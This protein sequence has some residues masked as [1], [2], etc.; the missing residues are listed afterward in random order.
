[1]TWSPAAA[2]LYG[3]GQT[4]VV[5]MRELPAGAGGSSPAQTP[6]PAPAVPQA[7]LLMRPAATPATG[8]VISWVSHDDGNPRARHFPGLIQDPGWNAMPGYIRR[9]GGYDFLISNPPFPQTP[10]SS[11]PAPAPGPEDAAMLA[12]FEANFPAMND[13]A[14][15][16]VARLVSTPAPAPAANDRRFWRLRVDWSVDSDHDGT[17]DWLE[18]R[19]AFQP[20][21]APLADAF[22]GDVNANG[23]A[24]GEETD[25]DGD[26]SPNDTDVCQADAMIDWS[27]E[28]AARFASFPVTPPAGKTWTWPAQ[29]N[30]LGDALFED[31]IWTGGV[32]HALQS[33]G[34]ITDPKGLFLDDNGS[35]YAWGALDGA[36][37][38]DT[39]F[40][41]ILDRNG[42]NPRPVM[43]DG[44]PPKYARIF[45]SEYLLFS[46]DMRA[47]RVS[48][49]PSTFAVIGGV[50][51][52]V[53]PEEPDLYMPWSDEALI[54]YRFRW[55]IAA[56]GSIS[57]GDAVG[58][59]TFALAPGVP[60]GGALQEWGH[61]S[62]AAGPYIGSEI[63]G[64]SYTR[65]VSLPMGNPAVLSPDRPA[66]FRSRLDGSWKTPST[67][68]EEQ[69]MDV[70]TGI[71]ALFLKRG[72]IWQNGQLLGMKELLGEVPAG[73]N[74]GDDL[75][76]LD[77]SRHGWFLGRRTGQGGADTC[78]VG[79][80]LQIEGVMPEHVDPVT[81]TT[82]PEAIGDP[83]AG[84]DWVSAFSSPTAKGHQNKLWIMAP[85]GEA[86]TTVMLRSGAS[87]RTSL[88]LSSDKAVPEP[89]VIDA[90]DH[91]FTIHGSGTA[92]AEDA[93][94][95]S[96]GS[97]KATSTPIGVKV[98]KRR[99]I[100]VAVHPV[101]YQDANGTVLAPAYQPTEAKLEAILNRV[102]GKQANAYFNCTVL[103]QQDIHFDLNA[104]SKL[105]VSFDTALGEELEA[106]CTGRLSPNSGANIDI[107][108][109]A[110]VQ[111]VKGPLTFAGFKIGLRKDP[112]AILSA[113]SIVENSSPAWGEKVVAHEIGHMLI[114]PGHPDD[115]TSIASLEGSE[116]YHW[117]R[118]MQSGFNLRD[119]ER[120]IQLV[121]TEWDEIDK[122]LKAQEVA[123]NL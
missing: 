36:E 34:R 83:A 98:M 82:A 74:A 63:F 7:R 113:D 44:T 54:P 76:F 39:S 99:T 50:V 100:Q 42:G 4:D 12:A 9:L 8:I 61:H 59:N 11:T 2:P 105:D 1:M 69:I 27:P 72:I 96:L 55:E 107:W 68:K 79:S 25:S 37:S 65:C 77:A 91:K 40:L 49:S 43:E 86:L 6:T 56:D 66:L 3:L 22:N 10:P 106:A 18:F 85:L 93:L 75:T 29:V 38:P 41:A 122:W 52:P 28:P 121:K 71:S 23:L 70:A 33:G 110:G 111:L 108:I 94:F 97:L 114:H 87:S 21:G 51:V 32:S 90:E 78:F 80:P 45:Q 103:P 46:P 19:D 67:L 89:L 5:L 92:S 16:A 116:R 104:D 53:S 17:P 48:D 15:E 109:V 13:D 31:F 14:E 84:V 73:W 123:G 62:P 24:D 26:G 57:L 115:R 95:V 102:Y 119:K 117:Q 81:E 58:S 60:P 20:G 30:D 101:G 120:G 118:L 64:E 47:C 88:T 112:I 35:I